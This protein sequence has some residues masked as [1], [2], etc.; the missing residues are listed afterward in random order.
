MATIPDPSPADLERWPLALVLDQVLGRAGLRL[1][2]IHDR[3]PDLPTGRPG[4]AVGEDTAATAD[5][6]DPEPA[7]RAPRVLLVDDNPAMRRVLRGLLE[8]AG[9]QVVAEAVNGLEGIAQ[10]QAL[11]PDVCAD[12][13]RMPDW[14]EIQATA[15]SATSSPGPGGDVL[16][17]RG[18][19]VR[20]PA[21]RGGA[22]AFVQGSY[23]PSSWCAASLA[24]WHDR[25]GSQAA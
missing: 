7:G 21:R 13:L 6:A 4:R 3:D 11:L 14:T 5:Q 12:G 22:S 1:V 2:A 10:A 9:M 24:A 17:G 16:L 25:Y 15:P 19:R 8:D 23:R 20:R 18:R